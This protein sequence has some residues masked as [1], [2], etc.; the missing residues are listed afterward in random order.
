MTYKTP[1]R[2]PL[3]WRAVPEKTYPFKFYKYIADNT[4]K[5]SDIKDGVV[6]YENIMPNKAGAPQVNKIQDDLN[7]IFD[8]WRYI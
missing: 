8:N 5:S 3:V 7:S 1:M 4:S 6:K 2:T